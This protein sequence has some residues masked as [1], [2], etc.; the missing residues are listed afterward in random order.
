MRLVVTADLHY[1]MPEHRA[2]VLA[3]AERI[4]RE[5]ADAL[6]L[7]GDLFAH[8]P[9]CLRQCLR[10]FDGFQGEK[11]LVAGNHDLWT[12]GGDSFEIYDQ[13]IPAVARE[14]G[15][16]DLDAA[17]RIL[18]DV[19][20]VGTVGWYDYSFR[21]ESLGIP[22]R[23]YE[24]KAAPGYALS[25][26]AL[27]ELVDPDSS[28]PF[29][30]LAARSYWNDGRMIRWKL[31]DQA[32]T[33]LTLERLERQL[34]AVEGQVRAVVAITHHLPFAEMLL[35]RDDPSWAFG[36][37]FMGCVGLGQVLL[38]HE[39]VTHAAFGH[40]HSRGRQRIGHIEAVNVGCTYAKK[41]YE[42]LD[43]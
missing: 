33:A 19:G 41:R 13:L 34:E 32:F 21:D 39:K 42:V 29:K 7:A 14:C 2:A 10:L 30:A 6:A 4:C 43:I 16:H 11:L 1:E 36:N 28:L 40:S 18:G 25:H 17:P 31:D 38:R 37:A 20:I 12:E 24:L 26:P 9:D 3:V 22:L 15:F 5:K 35:R 8:S 27:R 23:F